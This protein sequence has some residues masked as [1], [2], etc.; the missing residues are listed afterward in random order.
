M[1]FSSRDIICD[2][3]END[4]KDIINDIINH[5]E[6]LCHKQDGLLVVLESIIFLNLN[7]V[8]YLSRANKPNI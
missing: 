8:F 7:E 3:K 4:I 5:I 6:Q 2:I 1:L